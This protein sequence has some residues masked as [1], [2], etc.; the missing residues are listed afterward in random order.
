MVPDS[1]VDRVEVEDVEGR[2]RP[3]LEGSRKD[4]G[5]GEGRGETLGGP[6]H[7]LWVLAGGRGR[8]AG[9]HRKGMRAE[10]G[11][12]EETGEE[13]GCWGAGQEGEKGAAEGKGEG[14]GGR[15]ARG[16]AGR[17]RQDLVQMAG[18]EVLPRVIP[19][20]GSAEAAGVG[21]SEEIVL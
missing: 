5:Q 7:G 11:K 13:E 3:G 20:E 10:R 9:G 19:D 6:G 15:S 12:G 8:Q 21:L 16:H 17:S 14:G 4:A 18:K 1:I 2:V